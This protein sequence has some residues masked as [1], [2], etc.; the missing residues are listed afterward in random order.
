MTNEE[1]QLLIKVFCES[2]PYGLKLDFYSHATN[3]HIVCTLLG[4]EPDNEKPVIAKTDNGAFRFT[5][6]HVKPFLRPMSSMSDDEKMKLI[7]LTHLNKDDNGNPY[8]E[9]TIQS[10]DYLISNYFDYRGLIPMGLAFPA[11]EGMYK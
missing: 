1:N 6:N 4:I 8:R 2:L 10:L 11:P 9:M 5:Q 7:T 3:E